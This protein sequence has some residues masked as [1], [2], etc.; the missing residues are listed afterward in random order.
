MTNVQMPTPAKDREPMAPASPVPPSGGGTEKALTF[1]APAAKFKRANADEMAETPPTDSMWRPSLAGWLM[2]LLF[3]G[4]LGF[5][6]FTAP[7]SGAVVATGVVKV[8]GNR[9]SVQHL[10][11]GIV[12]ELRVREGDKVTVGDIIVLLDDT[13]ARAE[14][15]VL[16]QQFLVLR[17]TEERLKAE[18]KRATAM[19]MPADLARH[20]DN[21]DLEAIW[22]AQVDQFDSRLAALQGARLVI[23]EKIAQL[24]YQ[25]VGAE[26][27]LKSYQTQIASVKAEMDDIKPLVDTKLIARPRYLQLER[28]G[29]QLEGQA[30]DT[31]ATIAKAKQAIAEQSQQI[32]QL[33]ND[34][35]TEVTRDLRDTQAKLLEVI[36]KL[37]NAK[38]VLSRMEIRT[39]YTGRVVGLNVFSIGGVI[40][41]GEKIM[42]IVPAED[43]LVVEA[44]IA[45]EDIS[46]VR[47]SM[48]AEIHLTAYKQRITPMVNGDVIQISADRL[49]DQKTG[50]P[51]YVALLRIDQKQLAELPN[52]QLYAGMPAQVIVPTVE[53]T[54]FDYLVGPLMQSF[55]QAFRQR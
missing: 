28:S 11:G 17:A 35:M 46:D 45:V 55:T 30:A 36:P 16:S 14:F 4:G 39:P 25:I 1:M 18:L 51:Y 29:I 48:R 37:S 50:Q 7:L 52:I 21:P 38:S 2:L 47:P 34:R 13:Q 6:A 33:E 23:R 20:A 12:K 8:E 19:S 41:R 26:A 44:Q 49:T 15:E 5:W 9:K 42:D 31:L 22:S 53:R 10:D 40:G 43:S 32:A 54:A 27:T 24:E 3:F